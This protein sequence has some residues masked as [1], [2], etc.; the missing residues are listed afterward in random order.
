MKRNLDLIRDI[1]FALEESDD[2]QFIETC[3]GDEADDEDARAYHRRLMMDQGLLTRQGKY[4]YRMTSAGHDYLDAIRDDG[5]WK[6]TKNG[7]AKVGG[8]TIGLVRDLAIA[9]VKQE[10][11]EK[12]GIKI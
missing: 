6:K 1:L 4:G 3:D 9:Y 2:W 8:M 5:I 10:A 7:A 11:N 12:L